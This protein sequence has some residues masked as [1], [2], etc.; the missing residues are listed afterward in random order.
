MKV[1]NVGSGPTGATYARCLLDGTADVGVLMVEAGPVLSSPVGMNVRNMQISAVGFEGLDMFDFQV[2]GLTHMFGSID[3]YQ[4]YLQDHGINKIVNLFRGIMY[5][6]RVADAHV[7]ETHDEI[8]ES[9]RRMLDG[10]S[11]VVDVYV[12]YLRD[13]LDRPFG[14]HSIHTLRGADEQ[15]AFDIVAR[16]H[17]MCRRFIGDQDGSRR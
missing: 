6:H 10:G 15:D 12:R 16:H 5:D 17:E 13:K 1:L 4:R 8:V 3:A 2:F 14:R 9:T 7:R 11:N